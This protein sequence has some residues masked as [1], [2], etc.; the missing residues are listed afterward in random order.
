MEKSLFNVKPSFTSS[1]ETSS[2]LIDAERTRTKRKTIFVGSLK[3]I[4]NP[5]AKLKL[6]SNNQ[7]TT[8]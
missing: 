8:A 2:A 6:N 7:L 1:L 4:F 3:L 5:K